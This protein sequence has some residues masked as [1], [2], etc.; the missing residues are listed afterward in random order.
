MAAIG[1]ARCCWCG[2][3][4]GCASLPGMH[5]RHLLY[6]AA[7]LPLLARARAA[8]S[9]RLSRVQS[10]PIPNGQHQTSWQQLNHDT[11]GRLIRVQSPLTVWSGGTRCTGAEC[12]DTLQ[13]TE[14]PVISLAAQQ[15][16]TRPPA[17]SRAHGHCSR[18]STPCGHETTADVVAAVN[19]AR[20]NN[21]RWS[22][23]SRRWP[24]RYLGTSNTTRS[25]L[26]W[27]RQINDIASCIEDVRPPG[28]CAGKAAAQ[29]RGDGRAPARSGSTPTT[30]SPPKA[31]QY[32]QGGGCATVRRRGPGPGR[33][34]RQLLADAST[35]RP[36]AGTAG[37]GGRHGRRQGPHRECLHR[38]GPLLGAEGRRRR[39]L[40]RRHPA[41]A[42]CAR[43]AD[44]LRLRECDD[45]GIVRGGVSSITRPLCRL[46][47]RQSVR[48]ELGARS[49]H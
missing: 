45:P 7:A 18:A 37:G 38:S 22:S 31:G 32:V 47:C 46:L 6:A 23:S 3:S 25:L 33:R 27:T 16:L 42:S 12:R 26:I 40:R 8:P 41:R 39:Q 20:Q 21:T 14:E 34:L 2:R 17:G 1:G 43:V 24:Q 48:P 11:Q 13:G 19:F 49:S 28:L 29:R 44:V 30:R 10:P 15:Y 35:A 5:R 36:A 4:C 9:Q